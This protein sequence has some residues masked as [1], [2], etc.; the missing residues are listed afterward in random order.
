MTVSAGVTVSA[1]VLAGGRSSRFGGDKLAAELGGRSV[2]DLAIEAATAVANEVLVVGRT[3]QV[4]EGVTYVADDRPFEGP[5]AGLATGLRMASSEIVLVVGGDMPALD[6]A[7]L[8][9]LV[10]RLGATGGRVVRDGR[11][12]PDGFAARADDG[13]LVVVVLEDAGVRRPLPFAAIREP[14][15]AAAEAAIATGERSLHRFLAGLA[16]AS[17][18]DAEWR[19]IDPDGDSLLDVDTAAD[20]ARLRERG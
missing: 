9:L 12:A 11:V 15:L 17:V 6:P 7:V 8:R 3:G 4:R 18:P 13:V 5:L 2:L 1:I 10:R 16:V 19:A 14:A 20:L